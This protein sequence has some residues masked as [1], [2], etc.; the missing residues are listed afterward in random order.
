LVDGAAAV[1]VDAVAAA[2]AGA[3]AGAEAVTVGALTEVMLM[4]KK[5][6]VVKMKVRSEE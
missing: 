2:G 5:S 4:F 1:D 6:R 3:G